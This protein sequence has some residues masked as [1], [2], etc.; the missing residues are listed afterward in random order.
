MPCNNQVLQW[1]KNLSKQTY[2]NF[3]FFLKP[4]M[5]PVG[6]EETNDLKGIKQ[7]KEKEGKQNQLNVY[8]NRE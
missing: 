3:F 1:G 2:C 7:S 8:V 4:H 5:R 6:G